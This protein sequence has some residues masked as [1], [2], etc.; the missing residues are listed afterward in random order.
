M[1]PQSWHGRRKASDAWQTLPKSRSFPRKRE[2]S[3]Y[4]K[5]WVPAFAATS[6][7]V[8]QPPTPTSWPGLTVRRTACFRTPMSRPSTSLLFRDRKDVDARDKR[9]HDEVRLRRM[10]ADLST[11]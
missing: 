4:E 1:L 2:S 6:G 9:G 10:D 3:F 7:H 11:P 8:C 5:G